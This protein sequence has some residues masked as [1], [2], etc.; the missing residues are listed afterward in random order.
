MELFYDNS[1]INNDDS[2]IDIISDGGKVIIV[3]NLDE[4]K[5]SY[6]RKEY[7]PNLNENEIIN[8]IFKFAFSKTKSMAFSKKTKI[9]DMFKMFF[10]ENKVLEKEKQFY[11]FLFNSNTLNINDDSPLEN[12]FICNG[13]TIDVNIM[14]D[15]NKD[16]FKGKELKVIIKSKGIIFNKISIGTLNQIKD[17]YDRIEK[18]YTNGEKFKK[19]IAQRFEIKKND[20][21]TFSSVGIRNDFTCTVIFINDKENEEEEEKEKE[22][23]EEKEKEKEKEEEKEKEKEKEGNSNFKLC[24]IF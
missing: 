3:E 7:L 13:Q 4:F 20:E 6:Y 12:I 9:R 10:Q 17:L 8:I 11:K 23:E 15:E 1:R 2:S 19:I 21:R 18:I 22:E 14:N 5:T 24:L 16:T